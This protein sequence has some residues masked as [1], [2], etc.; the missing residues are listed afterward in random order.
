MYVQY[1]L[2]LMRVTLDSNSTDEVVAL[3]WL[4]TE[5]HLME[6]ACITQA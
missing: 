3:Y 2:Y 6:L 5:K 4:Y 1:Q